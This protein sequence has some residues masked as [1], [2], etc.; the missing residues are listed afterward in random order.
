MSGHTL[1][2]EIR[3]EDITKALRVAN[4]AETMKEDRLRWFGHVQRG[5]DVILTNR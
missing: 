1:R 4:I 3:N 2:E 5:E